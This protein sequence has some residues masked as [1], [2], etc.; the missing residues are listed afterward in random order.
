LRTVFKELTTLFSAFPETGINAV[1][2]DQGWSPAQVVQHV[3]LVCKGFSRLLHGP[4]QDS[5]G[6]DGTMLKR[7]QADMANLDEKTVAPAAVEPRK[8]Q[9]SKDKLLKD[10][11]AIGQKLAADAENLDLSK[12][13]TLFSLPAYG[14]FTRGEAL[15]FLT[16]HTERHYR[17]LL[18]LHREM[19]QSI[20]AR[21]QLPRLQSKEK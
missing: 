20:V 15:A 13:C 12:T 16:F 18:Q 8:E 19:D 9:Y 21:P 2:G 6:G 7:L 3:I 1:T 14:F 10:L 17:Q 4:V 11:N 5:V